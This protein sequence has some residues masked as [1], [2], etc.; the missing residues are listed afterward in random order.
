MIVA[1]LQITKG[2]DRLNYSQTFSTYRVVVMRSGQQGEPYTSFFYIFVFLYSVLIVQHSMS[3]ISNLKD[4]LL[5]YLLG[6]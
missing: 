3:S 2:K 6:L 4:S 5:Y 1:A